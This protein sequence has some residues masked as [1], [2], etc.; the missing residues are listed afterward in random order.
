MTRT[1]SY[2]EFLLTGLGWTDVDRSTS[3]SSCLEFC[4]PDRRL[5]CIRNHR[6]I[7]RKRLGCRIAS[8][9]VRGESSN[10]NA[11]NS[12]VIS[13][14]SVRVFLPKASK[15]KKR[16]CLSQNR[17]I[18]K[19]GRKEERHRH[20]Y[21]QI[22]KQIKTGKREDRDSAA[23]SEREGYLVAMRNKGEE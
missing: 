23:D 8:S 3:A 7:F 13:I 18:N 1:P 6:H 14:V 20:N 4:E 12:E 10:E 19:K 17:T 2:F 9:E 16:R 11:K 5:Y 22:L 15:G 21:R